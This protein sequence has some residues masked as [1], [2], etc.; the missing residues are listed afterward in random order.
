VLKAGTLRQDARI[1]DL[2]R[3]G[4][5]IRS[6]LELAQGDA[7]VVEVGSI[8]FPAIAWRTTRT[9]NGFV[10]GMML[11]NESAAY[12]T[13]V[14]RHAEAN[15]EPGAIASAPKQPAPAA[16]R[17]EL[18][19]RLR[20]KDRGGNRTRAVVLAAASREEAIARTLAEIGDGWE[21]LEA[22]LAKRTPAKQD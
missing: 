2:S 22:D 1:L 20:V 3:S 17:P 16:P 8:H 7:L 12:D 15:P 21:I 9:R 4:L 18:W 13:L 6:D 5:S 10:I 19:W 11:S 14:E